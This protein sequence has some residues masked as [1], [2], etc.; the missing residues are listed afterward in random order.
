VRWEELFADLEAQ[1]EAAAAAETAAEI[2]DRTR[3]ELARLRLEDRARA[4]LGAAV[5][6]GVGADIV[7]D[8]TLSAAGAGWILVRSAQGESLIPVTGITWIVGL[9]S[10]ATDPDTL[11]TVDS[12]LDLGY[13]LRALVRDRAAVTVVGRD[14][15]TLTG[16]IDR[17]GAD[18]IDLA[19]HP[20][21]E[22][23]RPGAVRAVR[24][25]PHTAIALIRRL[26]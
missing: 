8:G 5:Q 4:A 2:S 3:R 19:E 10:Y 11:A 25:V 17:A 6:V 26:D 1:W 15:G 9:G 22:P 24:T 16:T 23:R 7:V 21:D 13:I 20:S 12:R 14:G 18:A